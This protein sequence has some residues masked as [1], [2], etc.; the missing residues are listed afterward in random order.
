MVPNEQESPVKMA[1]VDG[2]SVRMSGAGLRLLAD[3]MKAEVDDLP[4]MPFTM[5]HQTIL[6]ADGASVWA[7]T[8]WLTQRR[9]LARAAYFEHSENPLMGTTVSMPTENTPDDASI[10]LVVQSAKD[11]LRKAYGLK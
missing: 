4:A 6:E 11:N 9:I 5:S 1:I 3:E 8:I 7:V 10:S 2:P